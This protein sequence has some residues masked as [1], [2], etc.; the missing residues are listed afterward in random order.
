MLTRKIVGRSRLMRASLQS[1]WSC[2]SYHQASSEYL[3]L[4]TCDIFIASSSPDSCI[5]QAYTQAIIRVTQ[6][7]HYYITAVRMK[8]Y[9]S[10]VQKAVTGKCFMIRNSFKCIWV[11]IDSVLNPYNVQLDYVIHSGSHYLLFDKQITRIILLLR[12]KLFCLC[13]P[14][15]ISPY[16]IL[17]RLPYPYLITL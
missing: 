16:G 5:V 7:T 9:G 1:R 15:Q 17:I 6:T 11:S 12:T 10:Y 2:Q 4:C 8:I 13:H 14:C 3:L